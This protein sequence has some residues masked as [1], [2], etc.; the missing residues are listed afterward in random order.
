LR[1][2]LGQVLADQGLVGQRRLPQAQAQGQRAVAARKVNQ[3]LRPKDGVIEG[4]SSKFSRPG[5]G[6]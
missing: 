5:H 3:G 4:L 1:Q 6:R 2:P